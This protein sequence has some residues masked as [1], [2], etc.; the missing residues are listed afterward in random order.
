MKVYAAA[1]LTFSTVAVRNAFVFYAGAA[2][3][4]IHKDEYSQKYRSL[5][6]KMTEAEKRNIELP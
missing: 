5:A 3:L 1:G 4:Y 2:S 6:H